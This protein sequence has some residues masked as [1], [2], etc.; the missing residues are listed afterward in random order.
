[1]D[2][3]HFHL[4][5]VSHL[6]R[7]KKR[8]FQ[9]S[10]RFCVVQDRTT[11]MLIGAGEQ[12]NGLYFFRGMEVA[13]TVSQADISSSKLWHS[14]LGHPSSKSLEL[15][16]FYDFSTGVFDSKTCE[17]CIHAKQTRESFLLS[18]NKTTKIFELVHYDLW[19]TYR[20]T[21]ICGSKYFLT[22]LDD[23]SRESGFT[24]YHLKLMHPNI[25]RTL[26]L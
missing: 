16:H 3:L 9:I 8:I 22:F 23:F 24:C 2:G 6:T 11:W 20:T 17:V 7:E 14:R 1:M 4:I 5:S 25:S 12:L 19:G 10:D 15:L 13:S 21:S 18:S 26:L